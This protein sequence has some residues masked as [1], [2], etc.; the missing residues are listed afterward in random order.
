MPDIF[1]GKNRLVISNKKICIW[2][3]PFESLMLCV[4]KIREQSMARG[5]IDL[6]PVHVGV[7]GAQDWAK[8]D[9][10]GIKDY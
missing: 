6:V 1:H 9:T 8:K 5:E 2:F 10:S 7:E 4:D 3:S